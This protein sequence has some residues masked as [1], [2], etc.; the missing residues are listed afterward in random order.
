[1]LHCMKPTRRAAAVESVLRAAL[2]GARNLQQLL[3]GERPEW[4]VMEIRGVVLPRAQRPKFLGLPLPARSLGA[5]SLDRIAAELEALGRAPW[6]TGVVLRFDGFYADPATAFALRR[7]I[8]ALGATGKRTIAYLSHVEQTAYYVASA[9]GEIVA[10]ESAD[11]GLRGIGV[12]MTFMR[13]ALARV[14]VRFEKLAIDEYKNAF[15]NL[16]RQE[17]SPAQKEQLDALLD[18]FEEH[19][20]EAIAETR[21][22]AAADVRALIDEGLTSAARAKEAK[23]IDQVAYEDEVVGP[24]HVPL[25]EARRFL[26]ARMPAIGGGRV[27][28]VVLMGGIMTGRSKRMPIPFGTRM[29]GAE[30]LVRALRAAGADE[31]TRAVV[32]FVDSPGGS[33]L[34]SDLVGR[35]VRLL[36]EKKPVVAVMGAVAASGGYYVLT[37]ASRV[38]AAPTT[39]TGSIGVLTGK[40]VVE[41]LFARWGLHAEQIRRGRYAL[42]LDPAKPLGDDERTLLR[43][44][45]EEIYDR[46][47]ARVAEGRGLSVDRVREIARGRIWAGADALKLGLVDELGDLELGFSRA[48]ALAGLGDDAPIWEVDPPEELV[49]PGQSPEAMLAAMAPLLRETSWLV[50]PAWFR[51]G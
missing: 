27:A 40:L 21:K 46:F 4:V 39:V 43:R 29:A 20:T 51:W 42:L 26:G 28:L 33:A 3:P 9:A 23:L 49:L 6:L 34:A 48:R 38:I 1:M 17:M 7:A 50:L 10:P 18:R 13:D 15:D 44:A 47:V 24:K 22:L 16:V 19:F 11:M 41:D 35:E 36:R 25:N 45:N 31:H 37:H 32:L 8:A 30:S 2:A 5:H 14:G 12:S